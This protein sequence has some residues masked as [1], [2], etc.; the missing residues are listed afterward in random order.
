MQKGLEVY[1][2]PIPSGFSARCIF[3]WLAVVAQHQVDQHQDFKFVI[4]D[5]FALRLTLPETM[6][7]FL[8]FHNG[9]T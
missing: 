5:I 6:K 8:V 9:Y 1:G 4:Y 7:T 2:E 3:V